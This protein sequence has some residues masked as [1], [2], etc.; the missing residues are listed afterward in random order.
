MSL[1]KLVV[2]KDIVHGVKRWDEFWS[3][4][5]NTTFGI[6]DIDNLKVVWFDH[7]MTNTTDNYRSINKFVKMGQILIDLEIWKN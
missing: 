6:T 5:F 2:H 1:P 4:H 7:D 3:T